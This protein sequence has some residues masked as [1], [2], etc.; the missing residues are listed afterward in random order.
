MGADHTLIGVDEHGY[1][2]GTWSA[3]AGSVCYDAIWHQSPKPKQSTSSQGGGFIASQPW[4]NCFEYVSVG[5]HL[6]HRF[7]SNSG[8]GDAKWIDGQSNAAK[9]GNAIAVEYSRLKGRVSN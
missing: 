2:D 7:S 1:L 9:P 4:H 6:F 5:R 3:T 8:S